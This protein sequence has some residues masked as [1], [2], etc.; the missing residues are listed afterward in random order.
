MDKD[1]PTEIRLQLLEK[2]VNLLL[3]TGLD[4]HFRVTTAELKEMEAYIKLTN[5][6]KPD[7]GLLPN[8]IKAT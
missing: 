4:G 1:F 5:L 8:Q 6:E 2:M 7:S 3:K